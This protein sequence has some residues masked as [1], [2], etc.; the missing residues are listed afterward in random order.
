MAVPKRKKTKMIRKNIKL[1]LIKNKL[2]RKVD[3]LKT[4]LKKKNYFLFLKKNKE[5]DIIKF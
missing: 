3:C 5:N 1:N 2:Y 4:F